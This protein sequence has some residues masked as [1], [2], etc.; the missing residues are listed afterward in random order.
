MKSFVE[1]KNFI[2]Q[3]N[4][5]YHR[6]D[7]SSE[8]GLNKYAD[9]LHQ[10]FVDRMKGLNYEIPCNCRKSANNRVEE[11]VFFVNPANVELPTS[12]DWRD[13]GR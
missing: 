13:K 5:R 7:V 1:N 9:L 11:P 10:E 8:V 6:G 4:Q 12:V 3:H 2:A